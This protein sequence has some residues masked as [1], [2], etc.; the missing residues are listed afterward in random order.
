MFAKIDNNF[1][2]GI[3]LYFQGVTIQNYQ[4]FYNRYVSFK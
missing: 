1:P 4:T 2:Y 3:A